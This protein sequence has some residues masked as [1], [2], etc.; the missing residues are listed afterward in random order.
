MAVKRTYI[1]NENAETALARLSEYLTETAVPKYFSKVESSGGVISCYTDNDFLMMTIEYPLNNAGVTIHTKNVT[2]VNLKT[3]LVNYPRFFDAYECVNGILL[4]VTYNATSG[5][6]PPPSL[7]IT[8]DESGNTVI[9]A[10]NNLRASSS[11]SSATLVYIINENS[12][13]ISPMKTVR[14]DTPDFVKTVLAPFV[15]NGS[16]GNYTPNVFLQLFS[17]NTEQGTLDIDGIRYF[18]N[19]LWCVKDE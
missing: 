11:S 7:T 18:S 19:G 8:K 17:H 15:V 3:G 5:S 12:D 10:E 4:R 14:Y 9:V 1:D 2:S 6:N 16:G 13:E